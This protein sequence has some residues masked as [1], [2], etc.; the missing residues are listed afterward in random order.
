MKT[1]QLAG[2]ISCMEMAALYGTYERQLQMPQ[3]EELKKDLEKRIKKNA[4]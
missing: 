1:S 4:R 3:V 2:I